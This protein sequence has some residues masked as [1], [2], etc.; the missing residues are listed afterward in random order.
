MLCAFSSESFAPLQVSAAASLPSLTSSGSNIYVT[1]SLIV[2]QFDLSRSIIATFYPQDQGQEF[3]LEIALL[4]VMELSATNQT[5]SSQVLDSLSLQGLNW[6]FTSLGNASEIQYG[7]NLHGQLFADA[8]FQRG[9]NVYAVNISLDMFASAKQ[10]ETRIVTSDWLAIEPIGGPSQIGLELSISGWPFRS[11]Q[12]LLALRIL[13][14]GSQGTVRH[15]SAYSSTGLFNTIGIVNDVTQHQDAS[16]N[17]LHR[18]IA[19][20]GTVKTSNEVGLNTFNNGQGFDAD[21]YYPNFGNAMLIHNFILETS[22]SFQAA[23]FVP[24]HAFMILA[25][26]SSLL[27]LTLSI[28]YLSRRSYFTLR[29]QR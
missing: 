29:R 2:S 7:Q 10:N 23:S 24:I 26:A 27:V 1:G 22:T 21:I 16:L 18:A 9:G 12:D 3:Q 28:A 13:I 20:N 17:W 15:H 4:Q 8:H 19:D 6:K 25:G 11:P 5:T 14:D